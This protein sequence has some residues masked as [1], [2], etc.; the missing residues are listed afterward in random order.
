MAQSR[1]WARGK[2][3][4]AVAQ[5]SCYAHLDVF[6]LVHIPEPQRSL[7]CM[8]SAH[9]GGLQRRVSTPHKDQSAHC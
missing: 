8:Q 1:L 2:D 9:P 3:M 4:Q 6:L 5:N 7:H